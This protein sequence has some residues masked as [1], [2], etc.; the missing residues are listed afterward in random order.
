MFSC[1]TWSM[2]SSELFQLYNPDDYCV[3]GYIKCSEEQPICAVP[4]DGEGYTECVNGLDESVALG[5]VNIFWTHTQ[6]LRFHTVA[7]GTHL[8]TD[9]RDGQNSP[10]FHDYEACYPWCAHFGLDMLI[11]SDWVPTFK[12]EYRPSRPA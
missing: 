3:S 6:S 12:L 2:N 11:F 4:C 9:F 10:C 8:Q 1:D 7:G 5:L